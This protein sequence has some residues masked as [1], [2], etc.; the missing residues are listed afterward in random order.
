ML[1]LPPAPKLQIDQDI[2]I[3]HHA[4]I[5]QINNNSY[6]PAEEAEKGGISGQPGKTG[7]QNSSAPLSRPFHFYVGLTYA[8]LSLPLVRDCAVIRR[9][10]A[11]AFYPA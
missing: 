8:G 1:H 2:C 9:L 10:A 3:L 4:H 5:V 6:R 7:A 11:S